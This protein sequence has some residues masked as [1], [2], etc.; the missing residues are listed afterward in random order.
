MDNTEL[1]YLT[2][3]ADEMWLEMVTAYIDA[4]GDILYAGDEKEMLLR[5]VQ[6]ILMQ[7][8]AGIDNALRMDTLRYAQREYLKIYGEKRN[9][10][11]EEATK[12]KS[13]VQITFKATGVVETIPAGEALTADG[14]ILYTLV[15]DVYD[16]GYVQTVS[17]EVVCSKAGSVGNG[18][19]SG[20]QMQFMLPHDGVQNVYCTA[21]A[22]GGQDD[23]EFEVYRERIREYGLTSITTGPAAQYESAAKAVSTQILDASAIR[24]AAG[25]VGVYLLLSS[26]SGS[27]AIIQAVTDALNPQEV[28]PLT[29]QVTV[30]LAT[31][32]EYTLNVQYLAST[33]SD[34]ATAI[35]NAVD[36]Y[37]AWQ[38]QVIGQAFNP[39]KLMA[40]LYQAGCV[41]VA[42][43][44]GSNFDGGSVE[45]T[46]IDP[47]EHCKGTITLAVM[48]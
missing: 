19:L 13:T 12:A 40:M 22:A 1:H 20:T 34:V 4:G 11:Y 43:G 35:A 29:D 32:V 46:T 15:N 39:D 42:W 6:S 38:D 30:A 18:L 9:C 3:D 23:E 17:A 33:G 21:D 27:A 48:D 10:Y 36:E 16:L 45:Y 28:R 7:A 25:Q 44:T 14:E 24:L 8:F 5:G 31:P 26:A 2:Y 37:V 47:N 41:R